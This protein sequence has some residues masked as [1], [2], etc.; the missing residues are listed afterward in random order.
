MATLVGDGPGRGN[1]LLLIVKALQIIG[2]VI[3]GYAY[4]PM[5]SST[6]ERETCSNP[7]KDS[8]SDCVRDDRGWELST[9]PGTPRSCAVG[10][11]V[12][13][14]P[15]NCRETDAQPSAGCE[16]DGDVPMA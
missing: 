13:V 7:Q 6:A 1:A 8:R 2:W 5:P 15:A 12:A 3:V 16:K 9:A 10:G 11:A 14:R 4:P